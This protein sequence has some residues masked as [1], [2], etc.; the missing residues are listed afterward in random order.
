MILF[1][2]KNKS[3]VDISKSFEKFIHVY[4]VS[5]SDPFFLPPKLQHISLPTSGPLLFYNLPSPVFAAHVLTDVASSS[6]AGAT[7]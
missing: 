1:Q 4:S 2:Y 3:T 6:E 5:I 7:C